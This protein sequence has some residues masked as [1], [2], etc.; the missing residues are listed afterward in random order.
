M[1]FFIY[2]V[3]FLTAPVWF[4]SF[5][6]PSILETCH[7]NSRLY[8]FGHD[9]LSHAS[10]NFSFYP[11]SSHPSSNTSLKGLMVFPLPE[12]VLSFKELGANV[13]QSILCFTLLAIVVDLSF[14][15]QFRSF[16]RDHLFL[17]NY[18]RTAEPI[19][20]CLV[21]LMVDGID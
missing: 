8:A 7:D 11:P 15:V 20:W 18:C 13:F 4:P 9:L 19:F 14:P 17:G 10:G 3:S 6:I 12:P 1:V 16:V 21:D 2:P 5:F